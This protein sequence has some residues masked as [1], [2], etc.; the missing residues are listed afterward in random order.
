M[1]CLKCG[2]EIDDNSKFCGY[3]GNPVQQPVANPSTPEVNVPKVEPTPVVNEVFPKVD[4]NNTGVSNIQDSNTV[5]NQP[6]GNEQPVTPVQP[7]TP[8][9]NVPKVEPTPITAPQNNPKPKKGLNKWIFIGCGIALVAVAIV[10]LFMAFNKPSSSNSIDALE[11]TLNNFVEKGENSGTIVTNILIESENEDAIN[12]TGTVKYQK[13]NDSYNIAL[14]LDK[15][16][17]FDEINLYATIASNEISLY[18]KS[19]LVDMIFGSDSEKEEWLKLSIPDLEL[20][21]SGTASR[22]VNLSGLDKKIRL[23]SKGNGISH[24][25]LTVDNELLEI[26]KAGTT[27]EEREQLEELN[28]LL[29]EDIDEI[30][31]YYIYLDV[32][33]NNELEKISIDLSNYIDDDSISKAQLSI[34]FKDFGSTVV[35][36]PSEALNASMDLETYITESMQ[37]LE[38][39]YFE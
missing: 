7:S 15:S 5:V 18:T 33:D 34:K 1:K 36:I 29:D 31:T 2:L 8:E 9:V 21:L 26:I 37:N 32:N 11:K 27:E 20:D 24:Y 30:A 38:G 4:F 22:E 12:L 10:L 3:C 28:S 13:L 6:T 16:I 14:T 23:V 25:E 17:L 39:I 35:S 19:S